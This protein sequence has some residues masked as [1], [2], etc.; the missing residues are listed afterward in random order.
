M[1]T[2]EELRRDI[3]V[4]RAG[5]T[6]EHINT[7]TRSVIN[8]LEALPEIQQANR[9]ACYL[10]KP[11]EI[12]TQRFI[13]ACLTAGKSVCVPRHIDGETGYA[14]SWVEPAGAWRDGPWHIAEPAHYVPVDIKTV[15]VSIVPVVAV[16]PKGN[17]LGHGGGN[18][19][20][21][22]SGLPGVKIALAFSFQLIDVVPMESHDLQVD[23]IITE[24]DVYRV[25][26]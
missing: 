16:D 14:W 7:A 25:R 3:R 6:L 9:L 22:L 8:R 19:D 24:N 10:A 21:L 17:R 13:E 5:L 26:S 23:I 15:E 1:K 20:R 18:F 11:F 12:Q 4:K 2:K